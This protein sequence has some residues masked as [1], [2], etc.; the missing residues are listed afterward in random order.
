MT[1]TSPPRHAPILE[2]SVQNRWAR[3]GVALAL[4]ATVQVTLILAITMISIALPAIQDDLEL[5][6]SHLVLVSAGYGVSFSGLLLLG[7]RLADVLGRRRTLQWGLA[8]FGTASAAGGLAPDAEVLLAARFAQGCGAALA[9]PAAMAL[10]GAVFPDPLRLTRVRALWGGLAPIGA[11]A[12]LLLS[13]AVTTW[14][15]WRWGFAVPVAVSVVVTLTASRALPSG[16]PRQRLRLDV[17]GAALA[18]IA[19]AAS[20]YG[21][22]EVDEHGWSSARTA[23]PLLAALLALAAFVAVEAR[24]PTPLVPL[25]FF[26]SARRAVALAV[27]FMA[28]ATTSSVSFFLALYFQ[29]VRDLSA[30]ETGGAFLPYAAAFV[31]VGVVVGRVVARAGS[32]AVTV[33]GLVVAAAGLA[34]LGRIDVGGPAVPLVLAALALFAVGA[35]LTFSGATVGA[36]DDLHESQAGLASGVVNTAMELGAALGFAVLTSLAA[37][38]TSQLRDAG[39]AA[40]GATTAGYGF[41][42]LTTAGVGLV[43]AAAVAAWRHGSSPAPAPDATATPPTARGPSRTRAEEEE[44]S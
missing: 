11:A 34:L 29:Q 25:R 42:L 44:T 2:R 40:P 10:L 14:G 8:V 18:T 36:V 28:A 4:L 15:S 5:G 38:H 24:T 41:T 16:P 7:G 3:P 1:V 20:S 35:A 27:V 13:G 23:G 12:G 32:R 26:A 43:A 31:G 30:L 19:A 37:A 6:R 9:A 21:V 39:H 33:S 17:P 22:V